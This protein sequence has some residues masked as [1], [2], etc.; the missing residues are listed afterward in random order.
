MNTCM[1]LLRH[2]KEFLNLQNNLARNVSILF[3]V[4]HMDRDMFLPSWKKTLFH[5]GLQMKKHE[6]HDTLVLDNLSNHPASIFE[7]DNIPACVEPVVKYVPW[8]CT[9]LYR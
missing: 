3:G 2:K 5:R 7:S 9:L 8:L 1:F 6:L 4:P